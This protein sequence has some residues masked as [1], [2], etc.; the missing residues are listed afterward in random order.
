[1]LTHMLQSP[2][3]QISIISMIMELNVSETSIGPKIIPGSINI[4]QL[5]TA[6]IFPI[7][8]HSSIIE[9]GNATIPKMT[10]TTIQII[11]IK[12]TGNNNIK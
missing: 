4:G 12:P 6:N 8:S 2:T 3:D 11:S 9:Q 1:M 5:I 10:P 7:P